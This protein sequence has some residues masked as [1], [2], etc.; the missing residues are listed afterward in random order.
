MVTRPP[1]DLSLCDVFS[2]SSCFF[3]V[4][5][6]AQESTSTRLTQP[7]VEDGTRMT[8]MLSSKID[9]AHVHAGD[10]V[11]FQLATK[12]LHGLYTPWPDPVY[13]GRVLLASSR[14]NGQPSRLALILDRIEYADGR[15]VQLHAFVTMLGPRLY[16]TSQTYRSIQTGLPTATASSG[17]SSPE[18]S[19][20][21]KLDPY[22]PFDPT[23]TI[24][25]QVQGHPVA[26]QGQVKFNKTAIEYTAKPVEDVR[27]IP[28]TNT[29]FGSELI[30]D[31]KDIKLEKGV[32]LVFKQ[33]NP[34]K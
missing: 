15:K 21:K 9:I 18:V 24:N 32:I 12:S 7:A 23:K 28:S 26:V 16:E 11:K 2:P 27:L 17:G 4:P 22:Q 3:L 14:D 30:S 19:A 25:Q 13:F 8:V 10:V 20:A 34:Q 1:F 5:L 31:N 29:D 33:W 6:A